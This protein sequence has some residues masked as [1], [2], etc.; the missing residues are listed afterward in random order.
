MT[1]NS[2]EVSDNVYYLVDTFGTGIIKHEDLLVDD[3]TLLLSFL[4]VILRS[5]GHELL[6]A[7]NSVETYRLI[8]EQQATLV[9]SDWNMP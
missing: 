1:T 3:D 2:Q 5:Q 9:I 7:R 4:S 8:R 6:T